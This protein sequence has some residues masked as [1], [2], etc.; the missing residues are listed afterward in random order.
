MFKKLG[1]GSWGWESG[2]LFGAQFINTNQPGLLY[3]WG[4]NSCFFSPRFSFPLTKQLALCLILYPATRESTD[5]YSLLPHLGDQG[6]FPSTNK[7]LSILQLS[8][9]TTHLRDPL[10]SKATSVSLSL[11]IIWIFWQM[12]HATKQGWGLRMVDICGQD[13]LVKCN[14]HNKSVLFSQFFFQLCRFSK[15]CTFFTGLVGTDK[16]ASFW[17]F[18]WMVEN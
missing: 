18:L 11:E 2:L 1:P 16:K 10:L 5:L 8:N 3:V 13:A 14:P 12:S 4:S 9:A 17:S 6:L 7:Y 15:E